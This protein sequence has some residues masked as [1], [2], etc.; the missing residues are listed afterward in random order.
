MLVAKPGS[1]TAQGDGTDVSSKIKVIGKQELATETKLGMRFPS[2][3]VLN[4]A[5]ARS[6]QFQ[7]KLRS[8]GRFRIIVFAGNVIK[9][10]HNA[11]LRQFCQHLVSSSLLA[12]HLF[13][14]IDV[15]TLHSSKRTEVELLRDFP[16]VLHA[17]NAK[18]GWDYNS[19]YVDDESYHEGYV[20]AYKGYGVDRETGCVVVTRPDQYVGHIDTLDE[21]GFK[22]VEAYFKEIFVS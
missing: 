15:L 9:P 3:Q 7:Q 16:D 2:F 8:D 12:P 13:K 18:T 4:Q 14:D 22:G 17:F 10:Q 5:D 21:E 20:D 19:I 11:R 6:W 1:A